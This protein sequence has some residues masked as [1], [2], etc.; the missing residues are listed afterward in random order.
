MKLYETKGAPNPRRVRIF[1]AEKG[2]D[3]EGVELNLRDGDNLKEDFRSKNP[4]G[5]VPTLELDDGTCIAETI[6]ISRYLEEIQPAPPLF[7]STPLEKAQVEMWNRRVELNFLMPVAHA[8]RNLT[9]FFKDREPI[10]E[11]WGQVSAEAAKEALP[12]FDAQLQGSTW[13]AG[14]NFSVADISFV[15]ALDFARGTKRDLPYDLPGLSAW[16]ERISARPSFG[17]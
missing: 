1:L 16:Y 3:V 12:L 10:V 7:G 5:R 14:E 17:A 13:L 11:E 4:F 8:F 6:A 2:I 9:G 15:C